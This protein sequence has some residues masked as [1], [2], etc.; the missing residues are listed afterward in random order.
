MLQLQSQEATT[1]T[2]DSNSREG[3]ALQIIDDLLDRLPD[4]FNM[5]ELGARQAPD[6]RTPYSVVALQECERMNILIAEVRRSLKV[7]KLGLQGELTMMSDMETLCNE[8]FFNTVP[9]SWNRYAYPSLYP[10]GQWF[11]DLLTRVKELDVWVQ[12]FTLPSSV[13][14]GGLFNPQ[15]FLTAVMQQTARKFEWPLDKVC[16][17]VEV[18][19]RSRE[20]MG[21]APREGAYIHGLYMEG[22][23][24]MAISPVL[25]F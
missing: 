19:K 2:S 24:E 21:L 16:I 23:L 15:S 11:A 8:L 14:L 4:G 20:E 13:W 1:S 18:T 5:A 25:V 7:L 3:V 12:D 22:D 6:E 10:L 17:S 9:E